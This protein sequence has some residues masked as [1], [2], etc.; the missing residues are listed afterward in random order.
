M[1]DFFPFW[2]WFLKGHVGRWGVYGPVRC[3]LKETRNDGIK[4]LLHSEQR[5]KWFQSYGYGSGFHPSTF[6]VVRLMGLPSTFFTFFVGL[7][8]V[9][10]LLVN[11]NGHFS[12]E[13]FFVV[14]SP[15]QAKLA[16]D[17]TWG[18]D[19]WKLSGINKASFIFWFFYTYCCTSEPF[20]SC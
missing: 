18:G 4:S 16:L 11:K 6:L 15:M 7:D 8:I 14:A 17:R 1:G 3:W 12:G 2:I 20:F 5:F 19:M 13:A 10:A 9:D